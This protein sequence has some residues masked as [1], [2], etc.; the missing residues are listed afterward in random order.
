M[1]RGF[2]FF[3]PYSY[4]YISGLVTFPLKILKYLAKKN[5]I[6]ILTFCHN[7]NLPCREKVSG[8]NIIRMPFIFKISKGFISPQS[9]IYFL[10][11][12]QKYINVLLFNK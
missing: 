3:S 9:I 6:T 11:Y 7:K 8:I 4:P 10:K 1:I 12:T 5:D 2:L